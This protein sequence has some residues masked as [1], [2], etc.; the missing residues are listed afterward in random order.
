MISSL[1]INLVMTRPRNGMMK[2]SRFE[3]QD[4]RF[5]LLQ[6]DDPTDLVS[7]SW[8]RKIGDPTDLLEVSIL[9]VAQ[10]WI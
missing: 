9:L 2:M 1:L 10:P 4:H 6:I 7:D 5:L 3:F 8:F